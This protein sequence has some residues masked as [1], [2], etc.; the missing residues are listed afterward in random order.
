MSMENLGMFTKIGMFV[1][2]II[3]A[4]FLFLYLFISE[5]SEVLITVSRCGVIGGL[6]ASFVFYL[7]FLLI[8]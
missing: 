4:I 7:Y 5:D 3:A 2:C 1:S 8:T 6:V